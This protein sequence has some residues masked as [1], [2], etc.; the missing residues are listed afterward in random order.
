MLSLTAKNVCI[1]SDCLHEPA[2]AR[3]QIILYVQ[4]LRHLLSDRA[5]IPCETLHFSFGYQPILL[6]DSNIAIAISRA[7]LNTK[8]LDAKVLEITFRHHT[9][10]IKPTSQEDDFW[11][12]LISATFPPSVTSL[13]IRNYP[14][15]L[16]NTLTAIISKAGNLVSLCVLDSFRRFR[17]ATDTELE[18]WQETGLREADLKGINTLL[19]NNAST[20]RQVRIQDLKFH[21]GLSDVKERIQQ[22]IYKPLTRCHWVSN[23]VLTKMHQWQWVNP[24][25]APLTISRKSHRFRECPQYNCFLPGRELYNNL[26]IGITLSPIRKAFFPHQPYLRLLTDR[27]LLQ[28]TLH[29]RHHPAAVFA[30]MRLCGRIPQSVTPNLLTHTTAVRRSPPRTS[31]YARTARLPPT[32]TQAARYVNFFNNPRGPRTSLP[33]TNHTWDTS[34]IRYSL[35]GDTITIATSQK[36]GPDV[37]H[38]TPSLEEILQLNTLSFSAATILHL[39]THYLGP[40]E[41]HRNGHLCFFQRPP[42]SDI[43]M[44]VFMRLYNH[45]I[46]GIL[47]L[48]YGFQENKLDVERTR[49]DSF[50]AQILPKSTHT[51]LQL[52]LTG[53]SFNA[54]KTLTLFARCDFPNLQ[55]L[56]LVGPNS[57][58]KMYDSM[59][60]PAA[61]TTFLRNVRT[62]IAGL[63]SLQ[64]LKIKKM[65]IKT[66]PELSIQAA[67]TPLINDLDSRPLIQ[68]A[69]F[70]AM[71]V[72][73]TYDHLNYTPIDTSRLR[74]W[75]KMKLA[76]DINGLAWPPDMSSITPTLW[77]RLIR[78]LHTDGPCLRQLILLTPVGNKIRGLTLQE[79]FSL[80]LTLGCDKKILPRFSDIE[81][82]FFYVLQ[83]SASQPFIQAITQL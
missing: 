61:D 76:F 2:I 65:A 10:L 39:T 32:A 23:L 6:T 22:Y 45:I 15:D 29:A 82:M 43:S 83:H 41:H 5:R 48:T 51:L 25:S 35:S 40:I 72:P 54:N 62:A 77:L 20:L 57:D 19:R 24:L 55:E 33:I 12:T 80:L 70:T 53:L 49:E 52:C 71:A 11:V 37:T 31:R 79:W 14:G 46:P 9:Q 63:P 3:G 17:A 73:R 7:I 38:D 81:Y 27:Q 78:T 44:N 42:D 16:P 18:A 28:T 75:R 36:M 50:C 58:L 59:E 68:L 60:A 13:I 21:H 8:L 26:T 74:Y 4:D 47:N 66:P 1:I 30:A 67:F 64:R 56:F 34:S 69:L